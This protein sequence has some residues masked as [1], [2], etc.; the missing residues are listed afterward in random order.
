MHDG[1]A[2]RTIGR[3]GFS[4]T[5]LGIL[6]AAFFLLAPAPAHSVPLPPIPP[7]PACQTDT[8]ANYINLAKGCTLDGLTFTGFTYSFPGGVPAANQITL[9][10]IKNFTDTEDGFEFSADPS[11][12]LEGMGP[13]FYSFGYFV[14]GPNIADAAVSAGGLIEN[15]GS[16]EWQE[17]LCLDGFFDA[18]GSC[19]LGTYDLIEALSTNPGSESTKF[20]AVTVVDV[21]TMLTLSGAKADS[22]ESTF[23]VD[24]EFSQVPEPSSILL[25]LIPLAALIARAVLSSGRRS[26]GR[27]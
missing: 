7:I 16:Y 12:S 6:A 23:A 13:A 24:E 4:T 27:L 20:P 15:Q 19:V 8:L 1:R 14:F 18:S 5:A 2:E 26:L 11:W 17:N 3:A 9:E 21:Q 10:P 22:S 25:V